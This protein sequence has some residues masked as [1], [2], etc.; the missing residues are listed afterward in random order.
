MKSQ[1]CDSLQRIYILRVR[2]TNYEWKAINQ[3]SL[4]QLV[5]LPLQNND[6]L[7]SSFQQLVSYFHLR[8]HQKH[9]HIIFLATFVYDDTRI[10]YDDRGLL[11]SYSA[12]HSFLSSHQNHRSIAIF[13]PTVSSRQS[14]LFLTVSPK[15]FQHLPHPIPKPCPHFMTFITALTPPLSIKSCISLLELP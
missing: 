3:R 1:N 2:R 4:H 5:G 11:S 8:P 10:F 15:L 12:S 9:L 7:S 13:L 14:R 6:H